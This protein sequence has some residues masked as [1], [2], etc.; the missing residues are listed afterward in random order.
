M[1]ATNGYHY[2]THS[3]ITYSGLMKPAHKAWRCAQPARM[4]LNCVKS[5]SRVR[6]LSSA[7]RGILITKSF[8]L[9]DQNP[10]TLDKATA[11][12]PKISLQSCLHDSN[13]PYGS[14]RLH[15]YDKVDLTS[16]LLKLSSADRA[17]RRADVT[18]STTTSTSPTQTSFCDRVR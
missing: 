13:S 8:E 16:S 15:A 4:C 2:P 14:T 9:F 1:A 7:G 10:L 11:V 6:R 12:E 18:I 17:L 5:A 3:I